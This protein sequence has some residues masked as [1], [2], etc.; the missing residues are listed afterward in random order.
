M[1]TSQKLTFLLFVGIMLT[2]CSK[3]EDNTGGC[4]VCEYKLTSGDKAA[5]ASAGLHGTHELSMKFAKSDSP[6]PNGTKATF[7]IS[8]NEL[9]VEIE[10]KECITIKNPVLTVAGSTEIKFKDT[11][12]DKVTYDV[13]MT[14]N[15]GLNEVNISNL[16]G[17]WLGQFN[18]R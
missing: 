16:S 15:G 6:F 2:A 18:D 17:K 3:N 9:K 4:T 12:R 1:K 13:S 8:A 10:G 7:T 14:T 5:T 11:C